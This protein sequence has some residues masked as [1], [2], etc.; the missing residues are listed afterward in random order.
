MTDD[1]KIR[2]IRL[3]IMAGVRDLVLNL[4]D[5]SEIASDDVR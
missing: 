2:G 3:Q 1:L 5:I 4:A